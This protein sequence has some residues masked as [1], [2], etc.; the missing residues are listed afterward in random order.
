MQKIG[1][2]GG[3]KTKNAIFCANQKKK[4]HGTDRMCKKT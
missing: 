3:D 4:G 1:K 2:Q